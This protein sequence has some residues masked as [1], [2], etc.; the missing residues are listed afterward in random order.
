MKCPK[1]GQSRF[2]MVHKITKKYIGLAYRC[3]SPTKCQYSKWKDKVINKQ[4]V[5]MKKHILSKKCW[6]KP[7]VISFKESK[8]D[9]ILQIAALFN[10][11]MTATKYNQIKKIL[12]SK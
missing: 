3:V 11:S 4:N 12:E 9:K 5:T 6:C 10:D 7:E 8:K 2:I 1:C